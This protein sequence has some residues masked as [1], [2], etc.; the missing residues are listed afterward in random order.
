MWQK[1]KKFKYFPENVTWDSQLSFMESFHKTKK[2]SWKR[3]TKI[4]LKTGEILTWVLTK[5]FWHRSHEIL[6]WDLTWVLTWDL[7]WNFLVGKKI[8]VLKTHMRFSG[9]FSS[10]SSFKKK[11]KKIQ[12]PKTHVRFSGVFSSESSSKFYKSKKIRVSKTHVRFSC[13]FSSESSS[14]FYKSQK[15]R[16]PKTQVRFSCVFSSESSSRIRI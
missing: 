9:V 11:S 1:I 10:E 3:K 2:I 15:I 5:K 13:V 7:T 16:V 8:K 6:A 14:K 12:V 4:L